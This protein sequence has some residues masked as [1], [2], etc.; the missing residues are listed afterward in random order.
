MERAGPEPGEGAR[1][2]ATG[3]GALAA[4][5]AKPAEATN[6]STE[7]ESELALVVMLQAAAAIATVKIPLPIA[8][9][10]CPIH[11]RRNA[12]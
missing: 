8:L 5:K 6:R 2:I 7:G 4:P 10:A 11:I 3:N 12:G 9:T 1:K